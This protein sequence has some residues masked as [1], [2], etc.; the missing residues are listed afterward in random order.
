LWEEAN[1][2][3]AIIFLLISTD[4]I[5]LVFNI[6]IW[7]SRHVYYRKKYCVNTQKHWVC[8]LEATVTWDVGS[9]G[10]MGWGS[11]CTSTVGAGNLH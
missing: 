10:W 6:M 9:L 8:V 1:A 11:I 2:A 3:M 4:Y 7:S 5:L